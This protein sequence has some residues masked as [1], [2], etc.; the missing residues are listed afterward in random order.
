MDGP[1]PGHIDQLRRLLSSWGLEQPV[2][3][4]LQTHN[5][6]LVGQKVLA[7]SQHSITPELGQ[8]LSVQDGAAVGIKRL[9]LGASCCAVGR[10]C[11]N[12]AL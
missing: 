10:Q 9:R 4:M 11:D 8:N 3:T 6:V 7:V 5:S 1:T 12:A 2:Y